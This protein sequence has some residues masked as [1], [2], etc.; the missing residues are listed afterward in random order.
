MRLQI[1][2]E[3]ALRILQHLHSRR[4]HDLQTAMSIATSIGISYPF[5][6]KISNQLK[7]ADL[8]A[9]VQGRNG[10][11]TLGKSAHEISL[12]DVYSC[13]EGEISINRCLEEGHRC[14]YKDKVNCKTRKALHALQSQMVVEMS[15]ISVAELAS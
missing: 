1:S 2:T 12:Y 6:N 10:G 8:I 4:C 3:Y 9:T 5:F 15:S 7:K 14:T 11:Y 13:V